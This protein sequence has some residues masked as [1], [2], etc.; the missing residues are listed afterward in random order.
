M[1]KKIIK[2]EL[3]WLLEAINE[4]YEAL[5]KQDEKIPRIEFDILMDNLRKFYENMILL[6]RVDER[7]PEARPKTASPLPGPAMVAEPLA[8]RPG[9]GRPSDTAFS[10]GVTVR[11]EKAVGP[12]GGAPYQN[13]V[14]TVNQRK[15]N[16][17]SSKKPVK[18]DEIDL[19]AAEEPVFSIK[20]KEAREKSLGPKTPNPRTDSL[21][22]IISINEKFMFINELFD[23][24][25]R[26][27]NE[28]IEMLSGF[29]NQN[30]AAAYLEN[31]VKKNFW[32][33][34]SDAFK[35]LSELMGR[36]F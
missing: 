17:P 27:Y 10:Q 33:T 7:L 22:S 8:P 9:T 34:G 11:Y 18:P 15:E 25:L 4:Q 35:K 21:K 3:Q 26:E 12:A 31:I 28:T 20:L 36:R 13:P 6:Q 14:P 19:F 2:D 16:Q 29:T 23:G 30:E 1:N 24:N 5:K 32:D